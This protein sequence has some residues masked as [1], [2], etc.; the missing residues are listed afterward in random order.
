MA[1]IRGLDRITFIATKT[2]QAEAGPVWTA[3]LAELAATNEGALWRLLD[4]APAG[5]PGAGHSHV[6]HVPSARIAEFDQ[7]TAA[8]R[9]EGRAGSHAETRREQWTRRG[10]G[11]GHERSTDVTGL[12]VAQVLCTDPRR[13]DEWDRWYDAEHLPD[14]L[15]SGA[16]VS[17]TRWRRSEPQPG[18]PDHLT[19][20][21]VGG[22][23]VD[24]AIE[25]SAAI[26]PEIVAQGRKH[27]CHA[28][29]LTWALELVR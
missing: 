4:P 15:A 27:E 6:L 26:M 5:R 17:G 22:I 13:V 24:E 23:P 1:A 28:G 9:L 29:G 21:E 12:I 8:A 2:T 14:M 19:I 25:L 18:N 7:S 11:L 20:Y 3:W 16:F 10:D